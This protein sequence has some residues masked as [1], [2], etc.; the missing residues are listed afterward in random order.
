MEYVVSLK[1]VHWD[2]P[3][4]CLTKVGLLSNSA[5]RKFSPQAAGSLTSWVIPDATQPRSLRLEERDRERKA[6]VKPT[7]RKCGK[8]K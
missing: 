4:H 6:D 7:L 5:D 8:L 1:N 3:S 2:R